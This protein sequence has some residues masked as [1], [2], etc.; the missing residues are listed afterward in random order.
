MKPGRPIESSHGSLRNGAGNEVAVMGRG[1][2]TDNLSGCG[3]F[4]NVHIV[5][6]IDCTHCCYIDPRSLPSRTTLHMRA[7]SHPPL[8]RHGWP[9]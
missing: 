1:S 2:D 6:N 8:R 9:L 7:L 4:P 5:D 3:H